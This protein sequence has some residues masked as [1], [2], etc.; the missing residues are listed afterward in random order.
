MSNENKPINLDGLSEVAKRAV[1]SNLLEGIIPDDALL[2]DL[3][4]VDRGELTLQEFKEK[5]IT[6]ILGKTKTGDINE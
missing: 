1:I 4:Q 2:E 5:G 3:R 6:R